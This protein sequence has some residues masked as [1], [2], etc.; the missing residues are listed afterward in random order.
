MVV[1]QD[2]F[3]WGGSFT[4]RQKQLIPLGSAEVWFAAQP[5]KSTAGH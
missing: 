2:V 3:G 1:S 4:N 5:V